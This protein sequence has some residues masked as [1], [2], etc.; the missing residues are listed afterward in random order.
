MREGRLRYPEHYDSTN[1]IIDLNFYT[2]FKQRY[3]NIIDEATKVGGKSFTHLLNEGINPYPGGIDWIGAKRILAVMD[4]NNTHF[5]TLEILLHEGHMNV[6]DCNLM[7][8]GIMK[9]LSDK[10]LNEPWDFEGRLKPMVKNITSVACGSYSLAFIEH[11]FTNTPI[12][13]PNTLLCDN[14]TGRLQ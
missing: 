7:Q 8:S 13:P 9:H 5:V 11:L 2:N 14:T 3:D 10:L 1:R 4:M 12:Q 6:Y